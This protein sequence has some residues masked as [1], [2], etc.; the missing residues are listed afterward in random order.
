[1]SATIVQFV[2]DACERGLPSATVEV[3]QS[4]SAYRIKLAAWVR[5]ITNDGASQPTPYEYWGENGIR[6][7]V[8]AALTGKFGIK[9]ESA[10]RTIRRWQDDA[11][12]YREEDQ[13]SMPLLLVPE[14]L[15]AD[16]PEAKRKRETRA[17]KSPEELEA[18]ATLDAAKTA[19]KQREKDHK[20]KLSAARDKIRE[21]V[22]GITDLDH[23]AAIYEAT[24]TPPASKAK[25]AASK[26]KSAASKA[27]SESA[28]D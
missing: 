28:A 6:A 7:V 24:R 15:K 19:R 10:E 3:F 27:K 5:A 4:S 17:A 1:M 11:K 23:L 18:Q 21:A 13:S 14:R 12:M 26:A 22:K 9:H 8:I 16:T 2:R 25:S 20:A